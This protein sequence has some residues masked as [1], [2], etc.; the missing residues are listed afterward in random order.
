MSPTLPSTLW[1]DKVC[2]VSRVSSATLGILV[3]GAVAALVAVWAGQ[4]STSAPA[5]TRSIPWHDSGVWLAADL[6]THTR[7]SDGGHTPQELA[8]KAVEHGCDVLAITDHT[9]AE[10]K[11]ATPEYHAAIAEVRTRTPGLVVLTGLEWNVP[12][13]KGQDH[14]IVLLPPE[15]AASA[16][17]TGEFKRRFDDWDKKGENPELAREA[18]AWL[19]GKPPAGASAADLPVVFLNHPSRHAKNVAA[20]AQQLDWLAQAGRTVFIG[21]EGAP[22]H[23]NATPLG[24]YGSRLKPDD[25]W[26]PAVAPPDAAWDG[27]LAADVPLW[28]ALANSDFHGESNGDYWPCQFSTTWLYAPERTAAGALRA[29]RAGTFAGVHGGIARQIELRLA[30]PGLPRSALAGETVRLPQGTTAVLEVRARIPKVDWAGQANRVDLVEL[31]GVTQAGTSVVHSAPPDSDGS[32]WHELVVP[33]DGLII[34]A[35]G[36]RVVDDGPDLLF[37]TNPIVVRT[38][39]GGS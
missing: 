28:G 26:D 27:R 22:G 39:H 35:R 3:T 11:A 10:L 34:R 6:H 15:S 36:R 30:A 24:A 21:M 5:I 25:R 38:A 17:H 8:D 1:S 33:P 32:V 12:P 13:G 31:V 9:D 7:F 37:Y 2:A 4:R 19:H 29:L 20:V 18:F 16:E 23:Q 14:A